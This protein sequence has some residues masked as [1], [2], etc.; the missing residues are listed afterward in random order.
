MALFLT[1]GGDQ[2]N[3]KELDEIFVSSLPNQA[4]V[5]IIPHA[6]EDFD[7]ALERIEQDFSNKK[8]QG[9][10][11]V[12]HASPE[13]LEFDALMIEGG[14]TFELIKTMRES[15]FFG[16]IKQFYQANKP[17]YADSAGAIMLG[18]DVQTAFLG[19]DSDEDPQ[20]LQDYRGLD[21]IAPWTVHA[22]ATPDEREDLQNLLYDKGNPILALSENAGIFIHQDA[23]QS[24]GQE[25][26]EAV[27]FTGIKVLN[28]GE[29]STLSGLLG[30]FQSV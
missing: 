25:A 3:F 28:P 30:D 16:L 19:D 23:I 27:T 20:R 7:D 6:A 13:L 2:E 14:N 24:L 18:G 29:S 10:E 21:L 22:H 15:S 26:L 5:G 8:I 1:G 11:L 12:L 9:F 17:I 4:R